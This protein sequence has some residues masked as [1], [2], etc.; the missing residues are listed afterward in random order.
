MGG[1]ADF[2]GVL[3]ALVDHR[4]QDQAWKRLAVIPW[5]DLTPINSLADYA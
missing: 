5:R 1:P 3:S 4:T 2:R